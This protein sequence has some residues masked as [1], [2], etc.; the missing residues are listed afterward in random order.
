MTTRHCASSSVAWM[1][2][3]LST[4]ICFAV[5]PKY[6]GEESLSVM[7]VWNPQLEHHLD[8]VDDVVD[9]D[10]VSTTASAA[11]DDDARC[12]RGSLYTNKE[13]NKS[14]TDYVTKKRVVS[15]NQ[16]EYIGVGLLLVSWYLGG[17]VVS[18]MNVMLVSFAIAVR[19]IAWRRKQQ[20]LD[21]KQQREQ[22]DYLKCRL[23]LSAFLGSIGAP[24][25]PQQQSQRTERGNE[26]VAS[27][28]YCELIL[29]Y[30]QAHA[31]LIHQVDH[32]LEMLKM[33]T[34]MSLRSST[35][36]VERVELATMSRN[37]T[38]STVSL[39]T[40]R[41]MLSQ[42]MMK[43]YESIESLMMGTNA[44]N[45][46]GEIPNVV[47]L[48]WLRL[49][50]TELA[51]LLSSQVSQLASSSPPMT[52][53]DAKRMLR[54]S[55]F[56]TRES[57]EY[58][59]SMFAL[60]SPPQ[61][62]CPAEMDSSDMSLI[63]RQFEKASVALWACHA[64]DMTE[65]SSDCTTRKQADD[66]VIEFLQHFETLLCSIDDVKER[67]LHQCTSQQKGFSNRFAT[68]EDVIDDASRNHSN[69]VKDYE[70]SGALSCQDNIPSRYLDHDF[71][72]KTIVFSCSG[73][74]IIQEHDND[75]NQSDVNI[76]DQERISLQGMMFQELHYRLERLEQSEE[77]DSKGNA[78][79]RKEE[80]A[81]VPTARPEESRATSVFLGVSGDVLSEL[82]RT[83][84]VPNDSS[85]VTT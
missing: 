76:L 77:V 27:N 73:G 55:T 12:D 15:Q 74:E 24:P 1:M 37:R 20:S 38:R 31:N 43:Q 49:L 81:A 82:K 17:G 79:D 16:M 26:A 58:L 30:C 78:I 84:H 2:W 5:L 63:Y 22:E 44:M 57:T 50:R 83:L 52:L 51:N 59:A 9:D 80:A 70:D 13:D 29:H 67:L 3:S 8:I 18:L 68:E 25:L 14:S 21:T 47:T 11:S 61:Q 34:S 42:V 19:W 33:A 46:E 85:E 62:H 23:K 75:P 6:K 56:A 54:H 28:D 36:S 66:R 4:V 10:N 71:S 64:C 65:S 35:T 39:S 45:G 40:A 60:K 72:D 53:H 32:S 48:A 69:D 41:Q 7:H